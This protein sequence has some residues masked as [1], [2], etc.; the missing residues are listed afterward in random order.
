MLNWA[1]KGLGLK[2]EMHGAAA[3]Q[4]VGE[5]V[6]ATPYTLT[7]RDD[8]KWTL[9][10]E[11][12]V[13]TKTFYVFTDDGQIC[14]F[15]VVYSSLLYVFPSGLHLRTRMSHGTVSWLWLVLTASVRPPTGA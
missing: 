11:T 12:N 9:L 8:H 10:E 13:E 3:V 15:Q 4:S 7:T 14:M 1:R 5:Q 2:E 6:S